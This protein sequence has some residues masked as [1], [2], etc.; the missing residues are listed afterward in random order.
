MTQYLLHTLS[1]DDIDCP[2]ELRASYSSLGFVALDAKS[3]WDSLLLTMSGYRRYKM[4]VMWV[5]ANLEQATF[6][7][8][9]GYWHPALQINC[10]VGSFYPNQELIAYYNSVPR[11]SKNLWFPSL[12]NR[13]LST[14]KME[15]TH[16][17]DFQQKQ[18][19][20]V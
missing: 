2:G 6:L 3:V 1:L 20:F 13:D 19:T 16:K 18:A 14:T 4:I 7:D 9:A 10:E 15:E 17:L 12:I 11:I 8:Y 5:R